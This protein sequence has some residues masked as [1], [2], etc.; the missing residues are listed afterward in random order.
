MTS[1]SMSPESA[2]VMTPVPALMANGAV[3]S[4]SASAPLVVIDHATLSSS[5][6]L[7]TSTT[8]AP[9]AAVRAMLAEVSVTVGAT[10][11]TVMVIVSVSGVVPSVALTTRL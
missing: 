7:S 1:K 9:L 10:S 8:V 11:V 4:P 5:P 6:V 3:P 2:S